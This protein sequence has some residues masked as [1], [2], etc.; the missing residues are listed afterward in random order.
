MTAFRGQNSDHLL[1]VYHVQRPNKGLKMKT[2]VL[3]FFIFV[4]GLGMLA[5]EQFLGAAV[6][7]W[8][9]TPAH[10]R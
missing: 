1:Y 5:V 3:C 4:A 2:F 7:E 6:P 8:Q 10:Q 9:T